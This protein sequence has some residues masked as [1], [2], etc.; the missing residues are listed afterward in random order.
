MYVSVRLG[1]VDAGCVYIPITGDCLGAASAPWS[2]RISATAAM[3][4][5]L[6]GI[7]IKV[8]ESKD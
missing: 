4:G 6:I 5:L 8:V 2:V 3:S 1:L 7:I